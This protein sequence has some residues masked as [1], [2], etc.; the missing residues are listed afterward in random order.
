MAAYACIE[1]R[2]RSGDIA[3]GDWVFEQ[4]G[5]RQRKE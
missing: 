5:L 2:T 3:I 4:N 1:T